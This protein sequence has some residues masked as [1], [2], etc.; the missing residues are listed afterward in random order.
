MARPGYLSIYADE[1]TQKI[2]NEFT[3]Q[4]GISKSNALS[5]MMQIYMLSQDEN[6][7][8]QLVK[9]SMNI[10]RAKEL[11]EAREDTIRM[12]DYIF[13]KLGTSYSHM[14]KEMDGEQTIQAYQRAIQKHGYSWFSTMSLH[15]GM[16]KEKVQFYND[17]IEAGNEVKVL[18]ALGQG[19]ND[20]RYSA[21]LQQIVSSRDEIKCPDNPAVVP[22]EFGPEERG[23]IWFKLTDLQEETK[24]TADMLKFRRD[25]GSVKA[26]ITSS[27]CHFGYVY[28]A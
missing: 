2:F 15:T 24:I 16:A 14:G 25:N 27:Q 1:R 9:E 22:P 3:R 13:M 4:K 28:I 11:I 8:L 21:V 12:N 18:F 23:K 17:M 6:L 10:T 19:I 7:Y 26:A 20:V 5:E